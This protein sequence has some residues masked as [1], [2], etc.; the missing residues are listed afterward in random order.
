M[1]NKLER[2]MAAVAVTAAAAVSAGMLPVNVF[3][4]TA[5]AHMSS[6]E[7]VGTKIENGGFEGYQYSGSNQ[8]DQSNIP[9][10]STT[11]KEGLIEL[12]K[13]NT[14]AYI[15]GMTLTPVEG[16]QGAE[17]NAD[18]AS[19][20]YQ[21]VSAEQ[22]ATLEWGLSHRGRFG[23][24]TML[25]CIGPKQ[26]ND[27]KKKA[28]EDNTEDSMD[29]FMKMGA[30]IEKNYGD[31][32]I[33][34]SNGVCKRYIVYSRK[35]SDDGSFI[36]P[37][38]TSGC[39]GTKADGFKGDF[40]TYK[41]D[42]F[43][44][45]WNIW[46]I[47]SV[48][49]TWVDYGSNISKDRSGRNDIVD[50]DSNIDYTYTVPYENTE[51]KSANELI[52]AFTAYKTAKK[53]YKGY[54]TVGNLLDDIN[55]A[56]KYPLTIYTTVGGSGSY[57]GTEEETNE[58][59]TQEVTSENRTATKNV[60]VGT[61]YSINAKAEE[62]YV[63]SGAF[64]KKGTDDDVFLS[65]DKFKQDNEGNWIIDSNLLTEDEKAL[66]TVDKP[67]TIKL[68]FARPPWVAYDP[69]GGKYENSEN[70]TYIT[71]D[72]SEAPEGS[73]V[74][75]V[76]TSSGSIYEAGEATPPSEDWRFKY[77]LYAGGQATGSSEVKYYK[78]GQKDA[79]EVPQ[80]DYYEEE[81]AVTEDD[82]QP[83]T[84][85]L[86]SDDNANYAE[87]NKSNS[88]SNNNI[89]F[90]T[91]KDSEEEKIENEQN[92]HYED[93][94][95]L[96][97]D[98]AEEDKYYFE[99]TKDTNSVDE[100]EYPAEEGLTFVAQWEYLQQAITQV[101]DGGM[102]KNSSA[103]GT[104]SYLHGYNGEQDTA[105]FTTKGYSDSG[106]TV[107]YTAEAK[108]G[109]RFVGWFNGEDSS[110][111]EICATATYS[112]MVQKANPVNKIYARFEWDPIVSNA[113]V[114]FVQKDDNKPGVSPFN[115]GSHTTANGTQKTNDARG[116]ESFGNTL[117]TGFMFDFKANLPGTMK[118][119]ITIPSSNSYIKSSLGKSI[120][121][122]DTSNQTE[123]S[124]IGD[125][126]I[127][128]DNAGY[129]G[130]TVNKL[131]NNIT[132]S[133]KLP[134]I[135][136]SSTT[137]ISFGLIIDGIYAPDA[138]AV[139]DVKKS[140]ENL[141]GFSGITSGSTEG[142][143]TNSQNGYYNYNNSHREESN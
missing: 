79:D 74:K 33:S 67:T 103:G 105:D 51:T 134:E 41:T 57:T 132:K 111:N 2:F 38:G 106:R 40:S 88:E 20:L 27:P 85:D 44:E 121:S 28:K 5:D 95:L 68:I 21:Y 17:L 31:L 100:T 7:G 55:F 112:Y 61:E 70:I 127:D 101:Y 47:K 23:E 26:Q 138:T 133:I 72:N 48:N 10:W 137:S 11:A 94:A 141:N 89:S 126:V 81:N 125:K 60:Y 42:E 30:W 64:V 139:L 15:S 13:E 87:L 12:F 37:D 8:I 90:D 108:P 102:W 142:Y 53:D 109:Y 3:A 104:I 118:L 35:F 96:N 71:N 92:F 49:S 114:S 78:D 16:Q 62:N 84:D 122:S 34:S 14:N 25:L 98:G 18:E 80:S 136:G 63:F 32:S 91:D 75:N 129:L 19:S 45:E 86:I 43:T 143:E 107:A 128:D 140:S 135:T 9:Y 36:L 73:Q 56:V 97:D 77:W 6:V 76:F 110:A 39:K 113:F 130:G 29:Q 115:A 24:D 120:N 93:E 119:N 46:M 54:D 1:K 116:G 66:L 58:D 83:E 52:F 4:D 99:V 131:A 22:G 117:S 65:K 50:V 82:S 123:S 59:I 124:Y 69:N